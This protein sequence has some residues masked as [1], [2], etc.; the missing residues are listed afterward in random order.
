[1]IT[2]PTL[3]DIEDD[4]LSVFGQ[5]PLTEIDSQLEAVITNIN[6]PRRRPCVHAE[7]FVDRIDVT[8]IEFVDVDR[9][10]ALV[11]VHSLCGLEVWFEAGEQTIAAQA[12]LI[13]V[14]GLQ[15]NANPLGCVIRPVN[16]KVAPPRAVV[17]PQVMVRVSAVYSNGEFCYRGHNALIPF[18]YWFN[19]SG[20]QKKEN[21][22]SR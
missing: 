16:G 19:A 9:R 10:L 7:K 2:E 14:G 21:R 12:C 18:G 11:W 15:G 4:T 17:V 3:G 22:S 1:V 8:T 5:D 6:D 13:D 20:G